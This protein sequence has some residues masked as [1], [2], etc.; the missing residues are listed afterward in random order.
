MAGNL[1]EAKSMRIYIAGPMTGLPDF[2][3]PLFNQTAAVLRNAGWEVENPAETEFGPA[4]PYEAMIRS[5]LTLL[6]RCDAIWMLPGW[7]KS[8][9]ATLEFAVANLLDLRLMGSL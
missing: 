9:E 7:S 1:C 5:G 2:N 6:L 4:V 3:Y 8:K